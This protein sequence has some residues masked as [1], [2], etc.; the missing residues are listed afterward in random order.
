MRSGLDKPLQ[1]LVMSVIIIMLLPASAWSQDAYQ[2]DRMWPTLQQPWYFQNCEL[3]TDGEDFI[4]VADRSYNH[5]QKFTL[6]GQFVTRWAGSGRLAANRQ[7]VFVIDS[8]NDQVQ[9]FTSDGKF[10]TH[11]GG[12]GNADGEFARNFRYHNAFAGIRFIPGCLPV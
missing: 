12:Q 8:E 6:D 10:V 11:W 4:Y 9:K 3:A 7:F 2:F 5:I 1:F